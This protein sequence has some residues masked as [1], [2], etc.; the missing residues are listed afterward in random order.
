[1]LFMLPLR[2]V[3]IGTLATLQNYNK[4]I[5]PTISYRAVTHLPDGNFC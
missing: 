4:T 2:N 1:M 5:T 3:P